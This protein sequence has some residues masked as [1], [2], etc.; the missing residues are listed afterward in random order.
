MDAAGATS[1]CLIV[2][3]RGGRTWSVALR[4]S[5]AIVQLGTACT[6]A[7]PAAASASSFSRMEGASSSRY[8]KAAVAPGA[9]WSEVG[10]THGAPLAS[11]HSSS[12]HALLRLISSYAHGTLDSRISRHAC[13]PMPSSGTTSSTP[14]VPVIRVALTQPPSPQIAGSTNEQ[15]PAIASRSRCFAAIVSKTIAAPHAPISIAV[16]PLF[17]SSKRICTPWLART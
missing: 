12:A 11:F 4:M 14:P 13:T 1:T 5:V 8:V 3:P 15:L 16:L 10:G 2:L 7:K 17:L 9:R 6:T